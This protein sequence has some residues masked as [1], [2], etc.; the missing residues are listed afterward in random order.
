V[1]EPLA[2]RPLFSQAMQQSR[3]TRSSACSTCQQSRRPSR[4]RLP[5]CA[6]DAALGAADG[7]VSCTVSQVHASCKHKSS[8]LDA[9]D[10]TGAAGAIQQSQR[11][12]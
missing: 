5:L 10:E 3:A 7:P 8:S 1:A 12:T 9:A 2:A 11:T 6:G 4:H